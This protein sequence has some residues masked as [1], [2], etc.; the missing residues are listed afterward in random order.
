[1]NLTFAPWATTAGTPTID[2]SGK[3]GNGI[4]INTTTSIAY[5]IGAGSQTDYVTI[6]CWIKFSAIPGTQAPFIRWRGDAGV[7]TH[8]T[9]QIY[10]THASFVRFSGGVVLGLTTPH[11]M[12]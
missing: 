11:G 5:N 10:T 8:V 1:D 2:P 3:T 4:S 12:T 9:L 7:T 6:G